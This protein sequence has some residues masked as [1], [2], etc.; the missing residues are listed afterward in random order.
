[1][2]KTFYFSLETTQYGIEIPNFFLP[3]LNGGYD[4][5]IKNTKI[6][7]TNSARSATSQM[8]LTGYNIGTLRSNIKNI[9]NL[10]ET[11]IVFCTNDNNGITGMEI[12]LHKIHQK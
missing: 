7:S 1:M 4:N 5:M 12:N 8:D 11:V 6:N 2:N 10:F 3:D 9:H